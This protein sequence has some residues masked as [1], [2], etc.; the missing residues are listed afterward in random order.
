[1]SKADSKSIAPRGSLTVYAVFGKHQQLGKNQ[2]RY[3]NISE[4]T[5]PVTGAKE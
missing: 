1:M 2:Y 3:S 4:T 5:D